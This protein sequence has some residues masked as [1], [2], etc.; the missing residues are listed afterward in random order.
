[1]PAYKTRLAAV[2]DLTP[3][4]GAEAFIDLV[5]FQP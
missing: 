2:G 3:W 1:V 5:T 4:C